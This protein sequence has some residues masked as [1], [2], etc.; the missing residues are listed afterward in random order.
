MSTAYDD[1]VLK[2]SQFDS[3]SVDYDR[4]N[5]TLDVIHILADIEYS[6]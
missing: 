3:G 5:W 1:S 2:Q 4:V 6:H